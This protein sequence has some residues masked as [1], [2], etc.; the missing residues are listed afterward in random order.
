[1]RLLYLFLLLVHNSNSV[2]AGPPLLC[3]T[4][5][6]SAAIVGNQS[7]PLLADP[8]LSHG[9]VDGVVLRPRSTLAGFS[10]GRN[11]LDN[12]YSPSYGSHTSIIAFPNTSCDQEIHHAALAWL[13]VA[14]LFPHEKDESPPSQQA[15]QD[16]HDQTTTRASSSSS[17]PRP[18]RC[19]SAG[20]LVA[21]TLA[22]LA[23]PWCLVVAKACAPRGPI[24]EILRSIEQP[25]KFM[26]KKYADLAAHQQ[27]ALLTIPLIFLVPNEWIFGEMKCEER[28]DPAAVADR[29]D[30]HGRG[31]GQDHQECDGACP[32]VIPVSCSKGNSV[33]VLSPAVV[34]DLKIF[35]D[36]L[37]K[38]GCISDRRFLGA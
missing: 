19:F 26:T 37:R 11:L 32:L 28:D 10:Q 24:K 13:S 35:R 21:G 1:M 34:E 6:C 12:C 25:C 7:G 16:G 22:T 38:G 15:E 17:A 23:A 31:D 3:L 9:V 27:S 14:D 5:L 2:L 8:D 4:A 36:S 30:G 18:N 29:G 20:K 33:A